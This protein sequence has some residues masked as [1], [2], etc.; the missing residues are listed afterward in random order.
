L[1]LDA[2]LKTP[3]WQLPPSANWSFEVQWCPRN[4]DLLATASF[5][6]KIGI[7]SLQA[8][9]QAIADTL[10]ADGA[11][12]FDSTALHATS[13]NQ[14]P[15]SLTQAP[16]WHRRPSS[17]A[18]GFGGKLVTVSNKSL[19]VPDDTPGQAAPVSKPRTQVTLHQVVTE[20]EIVERALRLENAAESGTLADFCTEK[21]RSSE[22]RK[23]KVWNDE[24]ANWTLLSSL[25]RADSRDELVTLLG[26]SKE[27]VKT[28]VDE[29]VRAFKSKTLA[30]TTAAESEAD[31]SRTA[32]AAS[33]SV[34]VEESTS[35]ETREPLVTV[36]D[37]AAT[38]SPSSGDEGATSST[39]VTT[40]E[41]TPSDVGASELSDS[42][43]VAAAETEVTEP[44]LFGDDTAPPSQAAADF[45]SQIGTD[46][47]RDLRAQESVD[48]LAGWSA[49]ATAGSQ[50]S[51]VASET[52]KST[53]AAAST[54][55]IYRADESDADRLVTRALILGDFESAVSIC[56]SSDR[57]ADAL[58][59]AVR[60][61]PELLAKTQ[62]AYFERRTPE[63][64]YLRLFQSIVTDDLSDVVQNADLAE[65]QEIFVVLCTFAGADDF[66]T[67]AE[68]L[69]QRLEYQ[70]AVLRGSA[71]P[72]SRLQSAEYRKNA[73]LCYLAAGKLEKVV[74]IWVDEMR[75]E[76]DALATKVGDQQTDEQPQA[77]QVSRYTTRAKALQTFMEKVTV[78][79]SAVKYVD[80]DLGAESSSSA[81]ETTAARV[82]KL[83][84][85]YDC[86]IEYAE[87]LASQGLIS[88]AFKYMAQTPT[89]YRT[90][91]KADVDVS[92]TRARLLRANGGNVPV[93]SF[94]PGA[95]Q[96]SS[97]AAAAAG[98]PAG[99]GSGSRQQPQQQPFASQNQ[100][101]S[102]PSAY[103]PYAPVQQPAS[104]Q[105]PSPYAPNNYGQPSQPS[106]YGSSAGYQPY[107]AHPTPP[108]Q[109][110]QQQK[111]SF[112][113]PPPPPIGATS[114]TYAQ[115]PSGPPASHHAPPPPPPPPAAS[116]RPRE[117][118]GW[119]DP[120]R[121]GS[122][123]RSQTP[124]ER[125][126]TPISSPFPN[127]PTSAAVYPPQGPYGAPPPQ[128]QQPY[129]QQG[130]QQP[131][132]PPP[133][134][135]PPSR[136][137]SR[138]PLGQQQQPPRG[139]MSPPPPL[140]SQ[141]GA[142]GP[143]GPGAYGARPQVQGGGAYGP[144]RPPSGASY[145]R[146]QP[147]GAPRAQQPPPPPIPNGG[148]PQMQAGPYGRPQQP[149]Q[150]G[151]SPIPGPP[152]QGQQQQQASAP[153][154]APAPTRPQPPQPKY[155]MFWGFSEV[156]LIGIFTDYRLP[157]KAPGDRSRG[158]SSISPL[159][160]S[161]V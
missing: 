51:S 55:Q 27:D 148:G 78:F 2:H 48:Q 35:V 3:A 113:P 50:P 109:Q 17:A 97:S 49:A 132:S 130:S 25:F 102:Q 98:A 157:I 22:G 64:P 111:T 28:R 6:G 154:P 1:L 81:A 116:A 101:V 145:Q 127:A 75:E 43:K 60:G 140:P 93:V 107:G 8:T 121:V 74:S 161:R 155:R 139:I 59:L 30:I 129:Y 7:H 115:P 117:T 100:P 114:P 108:Q 39:P 96:S 84:P 9:N 160:L 80:G 90:T 77:A 76:E 105:Q 135:P 52:L 23:E 31:I 137:A 158:F 123:R 91:K 61:G 45:Y 67:L 34:L 36:T 126:P 71:T 142:A 56:L 88:S 144:P 38:V 73:V 4:P 47:I 15:I 85:L 133:P 99:Y 12:I 83:A 42:T 119:N 33:G 136:G 79:Q 29:A 112:L 40:A 57:F 11:D 150:G 18:F 138:T 106:A 20:P 89:D 19:T 94:G 62:K 26:F 86:Y 46:R 131:L 63:S 53:A 58:I 95:A 104:Q 124:S 152:R 66:P 147:P 65:W 151:P 125:R 82:Y 149:P 153:A 128:Q 87:L 103:G 37:D 72:A 159:V 5:D 120:P 68:Q 146:Q 16:K 110:Q 70:F 41:P 156:V 134:P 54:F 44:S 32:S 122:P 21:T 10:P 143:A 13:S 14:H 24:H 69:G 141:Q 118:A 92:S